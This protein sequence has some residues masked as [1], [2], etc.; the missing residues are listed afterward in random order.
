M[1]TALL[2]RDPA[3]PL[4][5]LDF[6]NAPN[7]S[8]EA[9]LDAP[10]DAP[11]PD[12]ANAA[13]ST[14]DE[15]A[16]PAY[17]PA[18]SSWRNPYG[19]DTGRPI[20]N[21]PELKEPL[22]RFGLPL[23]AGLL[24]P[25]S[26]GASIPLGLAAAGAFTGEV[27]AQESEMARN[28]RDQA[29]YGQMVAAPI[30]AGTPLGP[31][32]K[33]ALY[34]KDA[35]IAARPAA[36]AT[37]AAFG[38]AI[39]G[40]ANAISQAIDTGEV[41][42]AD[43]LKSAAYGTLFGGVMG[44]V[45]TLQTTRGVKAAILD[46]RKRTGDFKSTDLE[47]VAKMQRL[48]NQ[49]REPAPGSVVPNQANPVEQVQLPPAD[50]PPFDPTR[51]A[52]DIVLPP[53]PPRP[54][55]RP[56]VDESPPVAPVPPSAPAQVAPPEPPPAPVDNAPVVAT[57]ARAINVSVD[58]N[59]IQRLAFLPPEHK[60]GQPQLSVS[61]APHDGGWAYQVSA[62]TNLSGYGGPWMGAFSTPQQAAQA[63][64]GDLNGWLMS[65][66]AS[67]RSKSEGGIAH[68][69]ALSQIIKQM[70]GIGRAAAP[71]LPEPA[72]L[73][74][75]ETPPAPVTVPPAAP[76][77]AP[78]FPA[79]VVSTGTTS[80]PAPLT[81]PPA[82]PEVKPSSRRQIAEQRAEIRRLTKL[83][84]Q[85]A[86]TSPER[87]GQY[88]AQAQ[89][90]R[91]KLG[92][93]ENNT[94]TG[95]TPQV[96]LDPLG[97]ADLL[98]LI[99]DYVGKIN[100]TPPANSVGGEYDG[101]AAAFSRGAAR[102][103]RSS[104]SGVNIVNAIAELN[105]SA[106]TKFESVSQFLEAVN[107]AVSNRQ[108]VAR[109]LDRKAYRD[110]VEGMAQTDTK[111]GRPRALVPSAP[112]VIDQVGVGGEFKLNKEKFSVVD[113][114]EGPGH[115]M[116]YII[117][118]GHRFTIPEG[119]PIYPD[120][121]SLKA[122][123]VAPRKPA[124]TGP[125]SDDPFGDNFVLEPDAPAAAPT[126]GTQADL[127]AG[128]ERQAAAP[129]ANASAPNLRS[130]PTFDDLISGR[131]ETPAE[132][133]YMREQMQGARQRWVALSPQEQAAVHSEL[134]TKNPVAVQTGQFPYAATPARFAQIVNGIEA[135]RAPAPA[136]AA[137]VTE[138]SLEQQLNA[139]QMAFSRAST[140]FREAGKWNEL[141]SQ[142]A[143][144]RWQVLKSEKLAAERT[145]EDLRAK[146]EQAPPLAAAPSPSTQ[147]DLVAG[148]ER[149][150]AAPEVQPKPVDVSL[151][152]VEKEALKLT[153]LKNA[154]NKGDGIWFIPEL[155]P[156]Q[157]QKLRTEREQ[158]YKDSPRGGPSI[159]IKNWA[160]VVGDPYVNGYAILDRRAR[161][162]ERG[163]KADPAK[164]LPAEPA[165][166]SEAPASSTQADL[167]AGI[168]R[169]AAAPAL[170]LESASVGQQAAEAQAA[171]EAQLVAKR[172]ADMLDANEQPLTGDSSNVNQGQLYAE[173]ADMFSGASAQEMAAKPPAPEMQPELPSA[174]PTQAE[175]AAEFDR[176]L[177]EFDKAAPANVEAHVK[178]A[179]ERLRDAKTYIAE[180]RRVKGS[181]HAELAAAEKADEIAKAEA[182]LAEFRKLAPGNNVDA[183]AII[184]RLGGTEAVESNTAKIQRL[185]G[186]LGMADLGREYDRAPEMVQKLQQLGEALLP[187]VRIQEGER[188]AH[189]Y[190]LSARGEID[191]RDVQ[192]YK[193]ELLA[194]NYVRKADSESKDNPNKPGPNDANVNQ[195]QL[196]AENTDMFSGASAQEMA[197]KPPAPEVAPPPTSNSPVTIGDRIEYFDKYSGRWKPATVTTIKFGWGNEANTPSQYGSAVSPAYD[198]AS[199]NASDRATVDFT[200]DGGRANQ[201]QNTGFT[202]IRPMTPPRRG[203]SGGGDP[204]PNDAEAGRID[205][206][207]LFPLARAVIGA[208][209]G[210]L[211]GDTP[212]EKLA[213]ALAGGLG[214]GLLGS[215]RLAR[216][217][218]AALKPARAPMPSYP[219]DPGK[220][221]RA[222]NAQGVVVGSHTMG[223]LEHVRAIE[224]PELVHLARQLSNNDVGLRNFPKANGMFQHR[225]ADFRIEL[226]RRIFSDPVSAQ[227]TM[228]HELGHMIDYLDDQTMNRGNLLGRIAVLRDHLATTLPDTPWNPNQALQPKDRVR[229]RRNA[230]KKIGKRPAQDDEAAL[231]AW[232]EAVAEEYV[233]L[234]QDEIKSR[235]LIRDQE[236]RAELIAITEWW[237]PYEADKVSAGYIDYRNSSVELYADALS[238]LFNAPSELRD[239]APLFFDSWMAYLDRKPEAKRALQDAWHFLHQGQ[240]AV[241]AARDDRI[242]AGFVKAEEFLINHARERELDRTT[243]RGIVDQTKQ[244]WWNIYQP[245]IARGK[246]VKAAGVK[247]PWHKD[248]EFF[249][250]AHALAENENYLLLERLQRTVVAPLEASGQT[251]D[252]LGLYL[253]HNRVLNE[254]YTDREGAVAGRSVIA[255]PDGITP[256]QARMKLM[257]QRV[258][259]LHSTPEQR[260]AHRARLELLESSARQVQDAFADLVRNAHQ[261]G[262]FTDEQL[263]LTE[264]NRYAYAPFAVVDYLLKSDH[265][266]A[267]IKQ[268]VG[269]LQKVG[270]PYLTF[271]LKGMAVAKLTE[272]NRAKTL[273]VDLLNA[274]FP[275]TIERA[276]QR[277]VAL[278]DGSM[279]NLPPPPAPRGKTT[280]SLLR[281]GKPEAYYVDPTYTKMFDD[282]MPASAHVIAKVLNYTM[283][284]FFHPLFI[285]YNP[286]FVYAANPMSDN[287]RSYYALPPGAKRHKWIAENRAAWE[288]ARS[289]VAQ[290][291][292]TQDM[293]RKRALVALRKQ[294]PLTPAEAAELKI[295]EARGLAYEAIATRA[296]ASPAD[297]FAADAVNTDDLWSRMLRDHALLADEPG[298]VQALTN[299]YLPAVVK[300]A[301]TIERHGMLSEALP[302]LA[303]YSM[304][305]KTKGW[306]KEQIAFYVRN[307]IGTPN[308]YKKGSR[309]VFNG[310][311]T[312][313][314]N[315]FTR[316]MEAD[317][318]LLRGATVGP[319]SKS[320]K[321]AEFWRRMTEASF[322]PSILQALAMVGVFG[323]ALKKVYDGFSDYDKT[324]YLII[325]L[326]TWETDTVYGYKSAGIRIRLTETMRF[327]NA[328]L[329]YIITRAFNNDPAASASL[330]GLFEFGAGQ[331]PGV[332][333]L[334]NLGNSWAQFAAGHQPR[335]MFRGSPVVQ[336]ADW[337]AGGWERTKGMLAYTWGE[338]GLGGMVRFDPK[339]QNIMEFGASATPVVNRLIR[340][341]DSGLREREERIDKLEGEV[342]YKI[343]SQMPKVVNELL[344]E[345]STLQSMG[346]RRDDR[347]EVRYKDL[348]VW[349]LKVWTP[350]YKE[351][352]EAKP[353]NWKT[354]GVS[355]GIDSAPY[356]RK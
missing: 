97:N 94:T 89:Q 294:R 343:R 68:Q 208:V 262:V 246:E 341:S 75:P 241:V 176:R 232:K 128:I 245:I 78:G 41:D 139:A 336:T 204:G 349:H 26:G 134:G 354:Y 205:P 178:S 286:G 45:E 273:T 220:P 291:V 20:V 5:A 15:S 19:L 233:L 136:P 259:A 122:A 22:T 328:F 50:I 112:N 237:R 105:D 216:R 154:I 31:A 40:G 200:P 130:E 167:V 266:P 319:E 314:I 278:A 272:L 29:S 252:D 28:A 288:S 284:N 162:V 44:G 238:V 63:A 161:N 307:Q 350:I 177:P 137:P 327:A 311:F 164:V 156:S 88:T 100:M 344:Q 302:K 25:V 203:A 214:L 229:L 251:R 95:P 160:D 79:A 345:Y 133:S 240:A 244:E 338:S 215:R 224:M 279:M 10:D 306:S 102:L 165:A 268:Q 309:A 304:L 104:G 4:S 55:A 348:G 144:Q 170:T 34:A 151:L 67:G 285:T 9:F 142:S 202:K 115:I 85:A 325:P 193:Q 335:D 96:G 12:S 141:K 185:T 173:D 71:S 135:A 53:V 61:I 33:G 267:G 66:S 8:A 228:A 211:E 298:R 175:L 226:D 271:V 213:F 221:M 111:K 91:E 171:R 46:L 166:P 295:L 38:G 269:T 103:L 210:Y 253:F 254:R 123:E 70:P 147:A 235:G 27:L 84:D 179:L 236:V 207:L 346:E 243:L 36:V 13:Q 340:W 355:L 157:L 30:I 323:A 145:L 77:S 195:G 255:N 87:A 212:E 18:K 17:S 6:L 239:R 101:L 261:A 231:A 108:S 188:L 117:Q 146:E 290:D 234:V 43:V 39:S 187:G 331:V 339:S 23:A 326:G 223:A 329:Q 120:K 318:A 49:Q 83:A 155:S 106:G 184:E 59:A 222:V 351:M 37:R 324:N 172:K 129:A 321:A 299:K 140:R 197:A 138:I 191:A 7:S 186:E 113:I 206:Q 258:P 334:V 35:L 356:G 143:R 310:S 289:R 342:V 287:L 3:A 181:H 315:V 132:D 116:L 189:I 196:Y 352:K 283:R 320:R 76:P 257:L 32:F 249:F 60:F 149:Q 201:K 82:A 305:G 182:V 58:E 2:R 51:S 282:Q 217:V 219:F 250:D 274:H 1:A 199:G 276:P 337:K 109:D 114:D 317:V 300:A 124:S 72:P 118:D 242:K 11:P 227:R 209:A 121:G 174:A 158:K 126:P 308:V 296:L 256:I 275:D 277:R 260:V 292:S 303:T 332:H 14:A 110:K 148:I 21:A 125:Q 42:L 127:V 265:V 74:A 301:K 169:Q 293:P 107:R 163:A 62:S 230:E 90:A 80:R 54:S 247:L 153:K 86:Q 152:E 168:E 52:R 48:R 313:Y 333:P 16:N 99:A 312:P 198:Q 347:Q 183:E 24:A 119:T 69:T 281:K 159:E 263:A 47:F 92:E 93:M 190:L 194:G 56:P 98:T 225:A 180:N 264:A 218:L 270:N 192:K 73:A 64:Q 248:P 150:A 316:G 131:V 322:V 65:Q 57:P 297:S 353:A 330:A 81:T 280:L